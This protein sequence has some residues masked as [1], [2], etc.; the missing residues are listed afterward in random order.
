MA[1]AADSP[2][3]DEI[4]KLDMITRLKRVIE[5][6]REISQMIE[7]DQ[8]CTEVLHN[9]AMTQSTLR[10]V[11]RNIFRNY[12][13]GSATDAIRAGNGRVYD[14]MMDVIYMLAR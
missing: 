10:G 7:A 4:L 2:V 6:T 14:E 9:L 11:A 3:Y 1:A 12:L 8:P 5:Q 13:K